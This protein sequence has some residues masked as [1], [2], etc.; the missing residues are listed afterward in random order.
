MQCVNVV[1]V[2]SFRLDHSLTQCLSLS[3]CSYIGHR[4]LAPLIK[5]RVIRWVQ[6]FDRHLLT[7]QSHSGQGTGHLLL[8]KSTKRLVFLEVWYFTATCWSYTDTTKITPLRH[9]PAP[10][11]QLKLEGCA[12]V[13]KGPPWIAAE[14]KTQ[15][16]I[17][18]KGKSFW[19]LQMGHLHWS[20]DDSWT[21]QWSSFYLGQSPIVERWAVWLKTTEIQT[22]MRKYT[23]VNI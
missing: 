1:Q 13:L 4:P 22:K 7:V 21:D 14:N 5:Q 18:I 9:A 12:E 11:P 20:M 16:Y 17:I 19:V 10:F 15:K 2:L 8:F 6:V 3:C 23:E